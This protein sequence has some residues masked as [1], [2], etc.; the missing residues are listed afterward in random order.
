MGGHYC[1]IAIACLDEANPA[2]LAAAPVRYCD[3]LHSNWM[4]PPP[5]LRHL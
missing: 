2:E 1:S 4:S 3:G 5:E